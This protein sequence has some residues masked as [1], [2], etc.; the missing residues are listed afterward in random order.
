MLSTKF[1]SYFSF[2]LSIT[3]VKVSSSNPIICYDGFSLSLMK[4]NF[5]FPFYAHPF[6]KAYE[7][8]FPIPIA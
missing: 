3:G 6:I 7:Q 1:L 2:T 4:I 5:P 8:P